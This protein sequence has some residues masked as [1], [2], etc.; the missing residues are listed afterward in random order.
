MTESTNESTDAVHKCSWSCLG[1][2]TFH[3]Q[4]TGSK[5]SLSHGSYCA[6]RVKE[7]F[8]NGIVFSSRA[9]KHNERIRLRV[10][11][12]LMN[13]HGGLRLG[14]TNVRPSS[15]SLPLPPMAI[16]NLTDRPGYWA[17]PAPESLCGKG[18]ELEFW[19][20]SGGSIYAEGHNSTKCKLATGV[21]LSK[22]LWAM[23]DI[24]GN[25][26]SIRLLGSKKVTWT[27]TKTSCP[28]P[29]PLTSSIINTQNLSNS[30]MRRNG[31]TKETISAFERENKTGS[32]R[33]V[34]CLESSARITLPCGHRCLC[35]CCSPRILQD[36]GSCPLCRHQIF[37]P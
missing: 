10:E 3:S 36:F 16:P 17:A 24:Y 20:S 7:T 27:V 18:S 15:M 34:V 14:F 35:T 30:D 1:P 5:V 21:D 29:E 12:D 19:V 28:V 11:K 26:F 31:G 23:I 33:C 22:P 2:L 4:A 13:W 9:V 8:K 37:A 25:T 6:H 32:E